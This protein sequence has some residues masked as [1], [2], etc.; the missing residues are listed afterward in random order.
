MF[1][2]QI[3]DQDFTDI[4][5]VFKKKGLNANTLT[6]E[7]SLN[8]DLREQSRIDLNELDKLF[9]KWLIENESLTGALNQNL[10]KKKNAE[11]RLRIEA[12]RKRVNERARIKKR[13]E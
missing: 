1:V 10:T 11:L 12:W 3:N 2:P 7:D 13:T 6:R 9:D 4:M 5:A 8:K